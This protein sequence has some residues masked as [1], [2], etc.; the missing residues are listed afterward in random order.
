MEERKASITTVLS[1][2][3][4]TLAQLQTQKQAADQALA[5]AETRLQ[6]AGNV[7]SALQ[8]KAD[9]RT[10]KADKL[11]LELDDLSFDLQRALAKLKML[12]D[13]EK[14]MDGYS[15]AVKA[16]ILEA[17][18]GRLHGIHATVAKLL[19]MDPAHAV[20]IETALGNAVQHIVCDTQSDAKAAI[21]YLKHGSLG[22]AT[23]QP[24]DAVKAKP[25]NETGL[26]DAVGFVGLAHELVQ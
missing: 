14:N 2:Q 8:M 24:I 26:D 3:N 22:R 25:L 9:L 21:R 15:G 17:E 19:S 5:D 1:Q 20:A 6:E 7:V 10:E 23:F 11:K 18:K 12:E 4:D 13:L 16:V